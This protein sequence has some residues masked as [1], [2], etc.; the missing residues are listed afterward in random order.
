MAARLTGVR[1][2]VALTTLTH[3]DVGDGQVLAQAVEDQDGFAGDWQLEVLAVC[4]DPLA[5]Y[6]VVRRRSAITSANKAL[7]APCPA[8]RSR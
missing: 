2:Q 4:S 5:G 3:L 7:D 1:G 6:E 8:G